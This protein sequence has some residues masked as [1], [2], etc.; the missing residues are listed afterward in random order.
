MIG[1]G[2]ND[3]PAIKQADLGFAMDEGAS[4]TKEVADIILLKNRFTL[5]PEVFEEGKK[6]V[7][8]VGSVARLFLTK[9]FM[10]IYLTLLSVFLSWEFPL[11]PRRVSLINIF[12]I[13]LPA[14]VIALTNTNT[15][16][17]KRFLLDLLSF[18]AVS[19]L[20]IVASGYAGFFFVG[21]NPQGSAPG[22]QAA[23]MVMLSIMVVNFVVSFVIVA[24]LG[25]KKRWGLYIGYAATMIAL[26]FLIVGVE[27][28]NRLLSLIKTFYEISGISGQGWVVTLTV[29][30]VSALVLVGAHKLR[31]ALINR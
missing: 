2:V 26:Y 23:S 24:A 10:L 9:N 30:A 20:V 18:V 4:I 31:L 21:A 29:C 8:T 3:V 7:N 28:N 13:G 11:T 17:H 16:R 14:M 6:I 22:P 5:L 19:A 27:V 12:A 15:D 25:G 1:D